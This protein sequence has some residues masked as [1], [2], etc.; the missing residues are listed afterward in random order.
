[1][2]RQTDTPKLSSSTTT[3]DGVLSTCILVCVDY[4]H[5]IWTE[6]NLHRS[7]IKKKL[8]LPVYLFFLSLLPFYDF[9]IHLFF[10]FLFPSSLRVSFS[11]IHLPFPSHASTPTHLPTLHPSLRHKPQ[12][13]PSTSRNS[14]NACLLKPSPRVGKKFGCGWRGSCPVVELQGYTFGFLQ[15]APLNKHP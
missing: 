11:P 2:R 3:G 13:D 1:M 8:I 9:H 14:I 6:E 5:A 12:N 15:S 10:F 7:S 4:Y